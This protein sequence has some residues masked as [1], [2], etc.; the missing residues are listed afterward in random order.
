[1]PLRRRFA[2]LPPIVGVLILPFLGSSTQAQESRLFTGRAPEPPLSFYTL[3]MRLSDIEAPGD[4]TKPRI[5]VIRGWE[6][7]EAAHTFGRPGVAWVDCYP[8]D[9]KALEAIFE[10]LSEVTHGRVAD[11]PDLCGYG[12]GPR[13]V[14]HDKGGQKWYYPVTIAKGTAGPKIRESLYSGKSREAPGERKDYPGFAPGNIP[15]R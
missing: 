13:L 1:M 4:R 9:S 3:E 10:S 11:Q 8:S 5:E 2:A 7:L 14:W 12:Y 15:K 6:V